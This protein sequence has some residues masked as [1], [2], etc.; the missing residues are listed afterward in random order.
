MRIFRNKRQ[1]DFAR[2]LGIDKSTV[3]RWFDGTIPVPE[4]LLRIA[5]YLQLEDE[6]MLFRHPDD[7]WLSRFFNGREKDEVARIRQTLE[8]AFP[9]RAGHKS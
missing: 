6:R 4:T 1:A 7:D 9:R 8:T 5:A 3:K 2:D